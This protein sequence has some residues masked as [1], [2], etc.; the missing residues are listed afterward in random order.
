[1]K[2]FILSTIVV[3]ALFSISAFSQQQKR[4]F[5]KINQEMM[6]EFN[7]T[8][9]CP[10]MNTWKVQIDKTLSTEDLSKLN[11][12]RNEAKELREKRSQMNMDCKGMAENQGKRHGSKGECRN[13]ESKA[14]RNEIFNELYKLL[15]TNENLVNEIKESLDTKRIEWKKMIAEILSNGL[16][17]TE[18][19]RKSRVG[20]KMMR[21]WLSI[22]RVFLF[23][24]A[25]Q[26][27]PPE[28]SQTPD[29]ESKVAPNPVNEVSKIKFTVTQSANVVLILSD[30]NGN[31]FDEKNYGILTPGDYEY[32]VNP[33]GLQPGVYIYTLKMGNAVKTDKFIIN[34]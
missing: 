4:D 13:Q 10:Q 17:N 6:Y 33:F 18:N 12:L 11:E 32:F 21:K 19:A 7:R 16:N 26:L 27:T 25:C 20:L 8:T 22:E 34:K 23:D 29:I 28:K 5:K 2:S 1:M 24:G 14:K 3:I 31:K 15:E 30:M 9:I